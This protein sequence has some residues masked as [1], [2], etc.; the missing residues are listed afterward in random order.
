MGSLPSSD[1]REERP[2]LG[3][4]LVHVRVRPGPGVGHVRHEAV[5]RLLFK[6]RRHGRPAQVHKGLAP[7]VEER[8]VGQEVGGRQL[9]VEPVRVLVE[10]LL[11]LI[12]GLVVVPD[13]GIGR[14][15]HLAFFAQGR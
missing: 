3:G 7:R 13:G 5:E 2:A 9:R 8:A 12:V 11:V 14:T 6:R 15:R 4:D 10:Q 1:V